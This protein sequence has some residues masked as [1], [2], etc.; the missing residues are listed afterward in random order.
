MSTDRH[1]SKRPHPIRNFFLFVGLAIMLFFGAIFGAAYYLSPQDK[2]TSA[3]A[4][5][6]VSGGQTLSRARRGIELYKQGLAPKL[7]FSGASLDDGP[8]NAREMAAEARR[9]GV[10]ERDIITDEEAKTTYQNAT[11]TKSIIDKLGAKQ[12]YLVTSPYHQRR[13]SVTFEK[14]YGDGYTF[15]NESSFDSRWSKS[16]WWATPFGIW[17]T[18]SELG[19]VGYIYATGNL[20]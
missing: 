1:H 9:S 16:A 12:I 7:I 18:L 19:K 3:D 14:V 11:N 15:I 17:I 20:Q 4:I 8:S 13:T 6:V 2:L 5:I 10:P